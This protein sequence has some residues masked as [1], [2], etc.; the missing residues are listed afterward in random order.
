M[1]HAFHRCYYHFVWT[2]KNRDAVIALDEKDVVIAMIEEEARKRGGI[3]RA[4]NMMPDHVHLLVSLPP[5]FAPAG[6]IGKVKGAFAYRYNKT[7]ENRMEW[8]EGYGVLTL[9]SRD[10]E[11]VERYIA[12]QQIHHAERRL[13]ESLETV[14]E[15]GEIAP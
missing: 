14:W 8:Q 3:V 12:N 10:L 6:Y 9:D 11:Q 7:H 1:G 15:E 13:Y 2:T 5:T 4:C